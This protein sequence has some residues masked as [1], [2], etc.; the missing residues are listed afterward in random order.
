[1]SALKKATFCA[2]LLLPEPSCPG[3][4]LAWRTYNLLATEPAGTE[5]EHHGSGLG[6]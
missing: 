3:A 6:L 4:G 5:L 1:M 2:P